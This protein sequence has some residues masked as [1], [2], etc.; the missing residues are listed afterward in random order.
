MNR[1]LLSLSAASFLLPAL[2]GQ[3]DVAR[4][5][6]GVTTHAG[7]VHGLGPD[8]SA[9]FDPDGITFTPLL[10][11]R[12]AVPAA[13][14]FTLASVRR[15]SGDVF[16]RTRD[17]A[18][19]IVGDDVRYVHDANV[20]ET[21]AVRREGI[22]QSFVFA[23]RPE[24][25]GDLVVR[26]E[27]ATALPLVAANPE[28]ARF[29][30]AGAGGVTFGAVVGV[31][32]NGARASGSLRCDGRQLELS[33][34]ASFVDA[35]AYPLVL[36]PLIGSSFVVGNVA[37]GSDVLPCVA[38]DE[39][40]QRYL[41][42]WHAGVSASVA[43]VRAQFV[44]GAGTAIV[45][46]QLLLD[47]TATAGIRPAVANV[48]QRNRFVVAWAQSGVA[49]YIAVDA[50]N[51]AT[52]NLQLWAFPDPVSGV[53]LGGDSRTPLF[54]TADDVLFVATT[55][56]TFGGGNV[57]RR[58]L[59]VGATGAPVPGT[60]VTVATTFG[61]FQ[62][63][64]VTAHAGT[65]GRWLTAITL[66]DFTSDWLRCDIV[67]TNG[68]ACDS[69]TFNA[70]GI[71]NERLDSAVATLDGS[72][73]LLCHEEGTSLRLR[74]IDYNGACG[75]AAMVMSAPFGVP[76][77]GVDESPAV[78]CARD[79]WLLAW[80]NTPP[81]ATVS[82]VYVHGLGLQSGAGAAQVVLGALSTQIDPAVAS[83]WSGGDSAS[84]EALVTWASGG[85]RA[86]SWQ[87]TGTGGVASLGGACGIQG[88]TDVASYS[89]T[90]VIGTSFTIDLVA[91]TAPVL[92]LIV[93]FSA[94][95]FAC[96]AC[97]IV[98]S[99]DI[100]LGGS[101][102]VPVNVPLDASL[103]GFE[104]FTQWLQLRN[105]GCPILPA[106]GFSNTLKFTIAE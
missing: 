28:G 82:D 13:L 63:P 73:F 65:A 99:P 33:L 29:E 44:T 91:P 54:G 42:V 70:L 79:R 102:P 41:V 80:R 92:A 14:R 93:G 39:T 45:G 40:T 50:S 106:F 66:R 1:T 101:G 59:Q 96:G 37:G 25:S 17:V 72:S 57:F 98:P 35:A 64:A 75:T 62:A 46:Q 32:A 18:P 47:S 103:I 74:R 89:G 8:Y 76:T 3:T 48:N 78:D 22:E 85:I 84:D 53:A 61:R 97:T 30:L 24:G 105:G 71:L 11:A 12:V 9:R 67:A 52:S 7:V 88:L 34:P 94:S 31:D 86:R 6:F 27:I 16:T 58:L 15:G 55:S 69:L 56:A 81:N 2:S 5:S 68:S 21:Y 43:E 83:K 19:A 95:P 51:G 10:G 60:V 36:D 26:G 104:L 100:L 49:S 38:Y 77:P 20:V 90:P 87:A 4:A 23:Q